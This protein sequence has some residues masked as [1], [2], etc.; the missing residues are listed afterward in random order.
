MFNIVN[1]QNVAHM[2]L[3]AS[4]S[5]SDIFFFLFHIILVSIL[6][7]FLHGIR[8]KFLWHLTNIIAYFVVI[9]S[10]IDWQILAQCGLALH[11]IFYGYFSVLRPSLS[12]AAWPLM[13]FF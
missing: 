6:Y 2:S 1:R 5:T 9:Y 13:R 7:L 3:S 11:K 4:A 10:S 8:A 12:V